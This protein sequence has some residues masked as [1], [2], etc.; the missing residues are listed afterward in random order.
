MTTPGTVRARL[1]GAL[2][3][4][5]VLMSL[6]APGEMA[7][8]VAQSQPELCDPGSVRQFTDVEPTGYGAAYI[9]CMRALGL[10]V[11]TGDGAYGP[12]RMLDRGQMAT[13]LVRLWRDVLGRQCPE[14]RSPFTDVPSGGT[15][16]KNIEC[17]YNLGITSGVTPTTYGPRLPL[18]A[19]QIS[20]FLLRVYQK[21]G[22]VCFD[23]AGSDISELEQAVDCLTTLKVQPPGE[24]RQP[25]PVTRAQM[26]VY[27]IGLWHNLSGLGKPP[28][29]PT[30]PNQRLGYSSCYLGERF[31]C[32]EIGAIDA[33]G[34][35]QRLVPTAG[36]LPQRIDTYP[37]WSPDG[38]MIAY[39]VNG[40][41]W[42]VD[43][44]GDDHRMLTTTGYS[45]PSFA[46][47]PD[48]ARLVYYGYED[49]T[50]L[51]VIDADG[52]SN[53]QLT[54][55]RHL[56][57]SFAWSP[58]GS[59]IAYSVYYGR[60]AGTGLWVIDADGAGNRELTTTGHAAPSFAW[61]PDGTR[62][63]YSGYDRNRE[64]IGLR[65]IDVDGSGGRL[66]ATAGHVSYLAWS[67][68]GARI[69]YSGL[70]RDSEEGGLWVVDADG[71][72]GRLLAAVAG[73]VLD[74]DWSPDGAKVAYSVWEPGNGTWIRVINADGT[75]H[76]QL[77][78]PRP[79]SEQPLRFTWLRFLQPRAA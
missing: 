75:N 8:A 13:F 35:D 3:G 19:S 34:A 21:T 4:L 1:V 61:S 66:L 60:E 59:R 23:T 47:S 41:I 79:G 11:G 18:K 62:I 51:W 28:A 10:S 74:V 33:D 37:T 49:G 42:T 50:G 78:G 46:W 58:D 53:R 43:A 29:P 67:P 27:L 77:V 48:S 72:G 69:V 31:E 73:Y 5:T 39:N 70:G 6:L 15:H 54:T 45:S 22:S 64:E 26:A 14:G 65:V 76:Q 25:G 56:G 16:S 30:I 40:E 24:G 44:D 71:S 38:A 63:V 68:D 52:S 7:P 57:P 9:L 55:A 36:W 20:R 17:L 2:A 32:S 12:D